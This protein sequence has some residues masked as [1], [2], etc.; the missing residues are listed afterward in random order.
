[1]ASRRRGNKSRQRGAN[2]PAATARALGV[3]SGATSLAFF[4]RLKWIDGRPLFDTI[5]AYRRRLLSSALDT[6]RPDGTPIHNFV[7]AGRGKKNWK[8][9]DL[10]L[11][12][13]YCLL[14]RDSPQGNDCFILANDEDQAGDDLGL[15]KK[16]VA[17]NPDLSAELE[18][19]HKEIRRRDGHGA[20]MVLPARDIAGSHGKTAH[21]IRFTASGFPAS[22]LK[23]VS[24][25]SRQKRISNRSRPNRRSVN[26]TSGSHSGSAGSTYNFPRGASC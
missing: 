22:I 11:A 23:T 4:G 14:M 26:V 20:L 8:S 18:V 2:A 10:V 12:G 25:P 3:R 9:A 24:L 1:M 7:L 6:Y 15:A 17:V 16:L 5:E 13:L 21:L 19:L